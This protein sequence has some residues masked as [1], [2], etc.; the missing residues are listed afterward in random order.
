MILNSKC[1]YYLLIVLCSLNNCISKL[2]LTKELKTPTSFSFFMASRNLW[3]T[4]ILSKPNTCNFFLFLYIQ[5]LLLKDYL[6]D[7]SVIYYRD[8]S[9]NE[10]D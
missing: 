5:S 7:L 9:I 1:Q 2:L 4:E 10:V 8:K 3:I 6:N